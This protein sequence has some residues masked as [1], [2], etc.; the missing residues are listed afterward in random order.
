MFEWKIEFLAGENILYLKS[1]GVMD[2][3]GANEMVRALIETAE[4]HQCS[5]HLVD[6]R[7]TIFAFSVVDFYER[8]SINEG[9]GVS[10]K[11]RTAMV[12][13]QLT[14]NTRF[15]EIVFQNRGYNLRH[16]LDVEEAKNWLKQ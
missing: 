11:F 14:E 12:F 16:F 10:R 9:L 15:M 13:S 5:T 8:P 7:E 4:V 3:N 6:H 2:V 1:K